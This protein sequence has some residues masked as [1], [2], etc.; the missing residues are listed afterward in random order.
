MAKLLSG[1]ARNSK[2]ALEPVQRTLVTEICPPAFRA[3]ALGAFQMIIGLCALPASLTA[4][5]LWERFGAVVPFA[6]SVV[7]TAAAAGLLLLVK[8]RTSPAT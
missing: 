4:G 7:F 6:L 5:L 8:E 2:G 1:V 3:S